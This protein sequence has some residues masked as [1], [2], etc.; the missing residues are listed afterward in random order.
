MIAENTGIAAIPEVMDQ[1]HLTIFRDPTT[2]LVEA[3]K[4]AQ[5]LGEVIK[6]K[7]NPVK[8][9]GEQYLEFE[10]WQTVAQFYGCTVKTHDA[11]AVTI[12]DIQGAKAVAEVMDTSGNVIGGAE[13][14]CMRDE[15]N[16]KSKPWFQLASMAQTRAG[17]K[18]L[19]NRFSWVVVLAGYKGTP[20]EEMEE[21]FKPAPAKP[22]AHIIVPPEASMD[23]GHIVKASVAAVV[24]KDASAVDPVKMISEIEDWLGIMNGGD[25]EKME[26]QLK[27]MTI[28]NSKK[29]GEEGKQKW[30]RLQ[31]LPNISTKLPHWLT[32]IHQKVGDIYT[33]WTDRQS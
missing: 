6:G 9:N 31:D 14:Y 27:N 12:N 26:E 25:R 13:S 15:Y 2:V 8:F 22:K 24:N 32:T 17:S 29:K 1:S 5:A 28:Y 10:D 19:R 18:A 20:A 3:R 7:S 11:V 21:V 16:W 30:L 23:A 33:E 4:A